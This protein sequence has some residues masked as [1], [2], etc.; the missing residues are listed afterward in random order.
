[1]WPQS[2][3]LRQQIVRK[4]QE[5][6]EAKVRLAAEE[7][8]RKA[9]QRLQQ[10]EE[11]R[12]QQE[13]NAHLTPLIPPSALQP[14]RVGPRV[15]PIANLLAIERAKAKV[16]EMRAEKMAQLEQLRGRSTVGGQTI[17]QTT[18]KGAARV[19]HAKQAPQVCAEL[20]VSVLF[21]VHFA[22]DFQFLMGSFFEFFARMMISQPRPF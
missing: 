9:Q 13:A 12:R 19:A 6:A 17:A 3:H 10:Q 1:M 2:I 20:R 11:R 8:E 7:A 4:Q 15:T 22:R 21:P 16:Q 5:E 14:P 18:P